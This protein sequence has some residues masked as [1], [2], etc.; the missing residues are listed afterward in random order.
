MASLAPELRRYAV[1][2]ASQAKKRLPRDRRRGS[3]GEGR[4]MSATHRS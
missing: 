3:R 1:E 4:R 2:R